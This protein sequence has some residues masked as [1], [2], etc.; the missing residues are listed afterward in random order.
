MVPTKGSKGTIRLNTFEELEQEAKKYKKGFVSPGGAAGRLGVSRAY[1]HQLEKAGL[2]TAYRIQ[3][4]ESYYDT[5]PFL[6]RIFVDK[7]R[8]G[9]YI[10]IPVDDLEEIAIKSGRKTKEEFLEEEKRAEARNK[11]ADE[12]TKEFEDKYGPM[13]KWDIEVFRKYAMKFQGRSQDNE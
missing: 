13:D 9:D 6:L 4:E 11:R 8:R 5:L 3:V 12:L 7:K 1:I 2:I 10:Y